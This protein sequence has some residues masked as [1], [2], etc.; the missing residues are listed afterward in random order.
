SRVDLLRARH[1]ASGPAAAAELESQ[2]RQAIAALIDW[3]TRQA[4]H[5]RDQLDARLKR[6]DANLKR[7]EADPAALAESR[8]QA[9]LKKSRRAGTPARPAANANANVNASPKPNPK[10]TGT[11]RQGDRP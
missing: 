5:E 2:L 11:A 10:P 6:L 8:L 3:E 1:A 9:A 7:L 4:R